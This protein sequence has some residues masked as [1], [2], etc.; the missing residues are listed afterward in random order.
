MFGL[1]EEVFLHTFNQPL[2]NSLNSAL[3][4]EL[5]FS[6][7]DVPLSALPKQAPP[8]I[9]STGNSGYL[10]NTD[11]LTMHLITLTFLRMTSLGS[12]SFSSGSSMADERPTISVTL[13]NPMAEESHV[14]REDGTSLVFQ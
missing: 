3:K 10:G 6:G 7:G 5:R 13:V 4:H 11:I 8:T 9:N 2:L 14:F 12:I 1:T